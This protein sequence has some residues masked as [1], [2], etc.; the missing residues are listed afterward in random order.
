MTTASNTCFFVLLVLCNAGLA[1]GGTVIVG[2]DP[3]G[4]TVWLDGQEIGQTPLEVGGLP[5][6]RSY[7]VS[8]HKAGYGYYSERIEA[9]PGEAQV[10]LIAMKRAEALGDR[11]ADVA[12]GRLAAVALLCV[13]AVLW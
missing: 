5:D 13:L 8:V 6:G 9:A 7:D 3:Q 1:V 12:T 4:A 10:V 11:L 2:T